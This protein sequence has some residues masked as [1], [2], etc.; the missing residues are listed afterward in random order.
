[1][2]EQ[3][4]D[5]EIQKQN[6][7][8]QIGDDKSD[9]LKKLMLECLQKNLGIVSKSADEVNIARNTHYEWMKKDADYKA[10][11]DAINE[12]SIDFAET[13]LFNLMAGTKRKVVVVEDG[14]KKL[15]EVRDAPNVTAIIFYLK[16]KGKGRGYVEK[17][18][19]DH[20]IKLGKDAADEE[21]TD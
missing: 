4:G 5:N 15:V 18:E 7:V 8:I 3:S 20:S 21:Y 6:Q 10:S 11:V 9:G 2:N 16:T 1:M 13:Q 14:K 17:M 19:I 12:R